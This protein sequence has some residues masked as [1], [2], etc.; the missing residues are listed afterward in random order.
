[1]RELRNCSL[2]CFLLFIPQLAGAPRDAWIA[3]WAASPQPT[4]PD[5]NEPLFNIEDQTVRERVRVS[6]GGA[7]ICIRLSN[8]YGSA[9]LLVGSAT[10]A[11]PNDTAS[12]RPGSIQT[13]TFEGRNSVTI[14]AGAPVLSDL[15]AFP[16]TSGA[17]ISISLYFPKRVATPTLH[18]L[19]LKRAVVSQHG[20]HTRA[21]KIEGGAASESSILV[22]AV[23]VPAQPSQRL[24]VAFGDSVTDGD[25]STVDADHNWPSDLIRRLGKTPEGSK[26]AVVN[27]G[28]VGNRLLSD[29]FIASVGCFGV[30]ALARFDR[31]ALALPGVTHIVLLEGINDIGFPG[32]KLG[33]SYLAGPDDVRTPEDLINA[34]RQL[35]SRAHAHGV[36]LIGATITPFED[37]VVPG[38]YSESK[39]AFRQTI[40][41]WIRTSGSFDG[42]IDFDAVLRDPD[43]PSRLLP[44]F[45][46]KDHLHPNDAGYRAMADAIDL[47]LLK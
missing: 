6:I 42:V 38:Y 22:S 2:V 10:V 1:M 17:E 9:P 47:A 33:G 25:G 26:L 15:V 41:K 14:P 12:V 37:V 7:Q 21:E 31:D 39:E 43:Q 32:A 35:I 8:E 46:S 18:S 27:E 28:I 11:A 23:L 24:V 45:S 16:V 13:V 40:N 3:T 5:P 36:K 19:A 44:R 20:D 4:A 34:Y 30:S 29:C